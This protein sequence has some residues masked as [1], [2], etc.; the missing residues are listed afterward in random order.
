MA[1]R[2]RRPRTGSCWS[3]DLLGVVED[4]AERIPGPRR[5]AAH[6]MAHGTPIDTPRAFDRPVTRREDHDLALFRGDRLAPRLRARPLL[7]QEE[8]TARI[9]A[10]RRLRKHVSCNGNTTSPY[11]S[12]CRQL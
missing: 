8:V 6:A 11:R 3:C 1:S 5:D 4:D 9:V 10:P 2:S 12:W 7:D